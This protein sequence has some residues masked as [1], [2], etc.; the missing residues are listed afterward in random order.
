M[1][2][3]AQSSARR[4][5]SSATSTSFVSIS[6]SSSTSRRGRLA[7]E[8]RLR[9]RRL[10]GAFGHGRGL[11]PGHGSFGREAGVI[12]PAAVVRA[13]RAVL[14]RERSARDGVEHRPV[15]RDEQHR[16][17]ERLE[18][19]LERLAALEVEVVR[20]LVEHEEVRPGRDEQRQRQAPALPSGQRRDRPLVHVPAGEEEAA[21]ERLGLRPLEPR[22]PLRAVEHAAA[23]VELGSLLREVRR[24]DAVAELPREQRLDERGLARA[25]GANEAD[26]LAAVDRE[27]HVVQQRLFAGGDVQPFDLD[28][29]PAGTRRVEELEAERLRALRERVELRRS[30]RALL[31]QAGDLRELRLRLPRL[32]LLV[33]EARHEPLEARDV[34]V[35]PGDLLAGGERPRRAL[36]APLVPRPGE[37]ERPPG[38]QL[39]HCGRHGFEEPA[40]VGDEDD[41]G[42]QRRQQLLEP[43][44]ARHV[45]VVGRLVEQQKIGI[46]GER[47]AQR[48]ARQLAAGERVE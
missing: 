25:V 41:P 22:R 17:G 47:A 33:A 45:E 12:G 29:G 44:E 24:D 34:G 31:V 35:V 23:L 5:S 26:V 13:Q 38:L 10:R 9:G 19:L 27:G 16:A 48:G 43:L 30:S 32:R 3:F 8:R 4:R 11:T 36:A 6:A 39:E 21:E 18:R 28:D 14:D 46:A 37:E 7:A 40:V 20:R 42:V 1:S 2:T 15:V